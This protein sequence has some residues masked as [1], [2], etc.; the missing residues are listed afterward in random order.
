MMVREP[1]VAVS[2][3]IGSRTSKYLF[4]LFFYDHDFKIPYFTHV[5]QDIRVKPVSRCE[6]SMG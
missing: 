4:L 6:N 2:F 5:R 1:E 3:P